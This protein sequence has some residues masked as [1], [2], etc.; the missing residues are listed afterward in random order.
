MPG[1]DAGRS[2]GSRWSNRYGLGSNRDRLGAIFFHI[3]ARLPPMDTSGEQRPTLFSPGSRE[4]WGSPHTPYPGI[5]GTGAERHMSHLIP[6]SRRP[7][8]GELFGI[9]FGLLSLTLKFTP[10]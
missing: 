7:P 5:P 6:L 2:A 10:F 9:P 8:V 1:R 4:G 3:H